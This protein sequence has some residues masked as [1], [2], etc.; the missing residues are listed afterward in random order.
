MKY[1]VI[2]NY[3]MVDV[4]VFG[5]IFEATVNSS[6]NMVPERFV[7][8]LYAIYQFQQKLNFVFTGDTLIPQN[9]F[10]FCLMY[11]YVIKEDLKQVNEIVVGDRYFNFEEVKTSIFNHTEN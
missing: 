3:E 1:K 4:D 5:G 10:C 6:R 11:G 7:S 2:K 9:K 8:A